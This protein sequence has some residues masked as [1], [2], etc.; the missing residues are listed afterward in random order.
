M[1]LVSLTGEL[2]MTGQPLPYSGKAG[3]EGLGARELRNDDMVTADSGWT[4]AHGDSSHSSFCNLCSPSS[5]ENTDAFSTDNHR[6]LQRKLDPL[7]PTAISSARVTGTNAGAGTPR[8][9]RI[10]LSDRSLGSGFSD[11][12]PKAHKPSRGET[13]T[14]FW[15]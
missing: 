12:M 11:T 10:D 14:E 3:R 9:K 5:S 4:Q 15:N 8:G 6:T 2:R 7:L 13:Y 1:A